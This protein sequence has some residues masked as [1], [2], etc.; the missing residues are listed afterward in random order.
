M[1]FTDIDNYRWGKLN[2][3]KISDKSVGEISGLEMGQTLNQSLSIN[4]LIFIRLWIL[5]G[6]WL[7]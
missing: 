5:Y 3:A 6:M 2:K 1:S 7:I 4:S